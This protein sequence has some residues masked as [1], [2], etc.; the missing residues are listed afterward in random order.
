ME[1]NK[2]TWYSKLL[3]A[4]VFVVL[5]FAGFYL[6]MQYQKKLEV[7]VQPQKA[8]YQTPAQQPQKEKETP[9]PPPQL[10]GNQLEPQKTGAE[11]ACETLQQ[12][13]AAK[14]NP[15]DPRVYLGPFIDA[16]RRGVLAAQEKETVR[17]YFDDPAL[18]MPGSGLQDIDLNKN[19]T[20]FSF[21]I[22][23][24]TPSGIVTV[25]VSDPEFN[26]HRLTF[27]ARKGEKGWKILD[28]NDPG[29]ALK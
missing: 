19:F 3:A 10:W 6:G 4:V 21:T 5:P 2:V 12:S 13:I 20:D 22:S 27:Y 28:I 29:N 7:S 15:E 11:L 26:A 25:D 17:C 18:Y 23:S 24:W 1:L 16:L 14:Q 8:A 9:A